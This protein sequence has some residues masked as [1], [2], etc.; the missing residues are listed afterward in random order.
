MVYAAFF[1][2]QGGWL[3]SYGMVRAR[4]RARRMGLTADCFD[5]DDLS[6]ATAALAAHVKD[7][8]ALVGYSLGC[9]TVTWLQHEQPID[10]VL[11]VAA[12]SFGQNHPIIHKNTKRSVLWRGSG[13]LSDAGA[14]WV[15]MSSMRSTAARICG[16]TS[17]RR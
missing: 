5:Y 14:I 7:R 8:I 12:S 17:R 6:G 9:T 1:F 11:C 3:T 13:A 16:W 10:L 15:L 4:D 2:G